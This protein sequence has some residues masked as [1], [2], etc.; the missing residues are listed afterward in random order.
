M[1]LLILPGLADEGVTFTIIAASFESMENGYVKFGYIER[2]RNKQLVLMWSPS[3][4]L[5]LVPSPDSFNSDEYREVY[6]SASEH[7]NHFWIQVI[8]PCSLLLDKLVSEM[9]EHYDNTLVSCCKGRLGW[10]F[11]FS[12]SSVPFFPYS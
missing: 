7:P 12:V 2:Y 4:P 8:E 10:G 11:P 9:T 5:C 1:S 3:L 6:V